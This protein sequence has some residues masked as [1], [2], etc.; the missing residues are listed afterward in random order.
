MAN[1]NDLDKL[2]YLISKNHIQNYHLYNT[3]ILELNSCDGRYVSWL[4]EV[5]YTNKYY[6]TNITDVK[7]HNKKQDTSND[8]IFLKEDSTKK[9][10]PIENCGIIIANLKINKPYYN[11]PKKILIDIY[12]SLHRKGLCLLIVK[13]NSPHKYYN[14]LYSKISNNKEQQRPLLKNEELFHKTGYTKT[15]IFYKNLN[16]TGYLLMKTQQDT[17]GEK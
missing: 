7:K 9:G 15:D 12:D 4:N 2:I 5:L 8:I 16:T 17:Y 6:C 10:L 1:S 3:N 14:E 11:I 13:T